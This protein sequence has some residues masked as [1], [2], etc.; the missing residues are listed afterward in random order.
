V[1]ATPTG[2]PNRAKHLSNLGLVLEGRYDLTG[3]PADQEEA[4]TG[5]LHS[6]AAAAGGTGDTAGPEARRTPGLGHR[7]RRGP[8]RAENVRAGVPRAVRDDSRTVATR[9]PG[10]QVINSIEPIRVSGERE[11]KQ[12]S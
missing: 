11:P 9:A 6:G 10:A 7:R 3:A 4:I 1:Q 2:H 5:R 12:R 8:G